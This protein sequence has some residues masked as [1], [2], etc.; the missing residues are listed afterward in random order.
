M[1]LR[2]DSTSVRR[3]LAATL[4]A[5]LTV[6]LAGGILAGTHAVPHYAGRVLYR[7]TH[8]PVPGVLVEV[9][10]A[11]DDG[12][13]TDEVLGSAHADAEG[14]FT[15]ELPKGTDKPVTLVVSAVRESA[16]SSG[17]RRS[18]GYAIKTHRILLGFLAH[19]SPTKPNTVL[20]ER[21]RVGRG[22]GDSDDD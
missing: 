5:A 8:G 11:E 6:C 18:E 21:R 12:K 22:S 16:D 13:P 4:V 3:V 14:R 20:I 19:P 15:V 17:D 9:V 10:E 2:T 7:A 1:S